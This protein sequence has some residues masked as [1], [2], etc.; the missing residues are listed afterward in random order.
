V[1]APEFHHCGSFTYLA[2]KTA[3]PAAK[4]PSHNLSGGRG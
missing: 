1:F 4:A 2:L 3:A